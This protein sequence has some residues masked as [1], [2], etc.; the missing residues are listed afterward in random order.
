MLGEFKYLY[1]FQKDNM[2]ITQDYAKM[3]LLEFICIIHKLMF[4]E[5]FI[6]KPFHIE[7]CNLLTMCA[8]RTLP[9][10]KY[11]VIINM[12]FR[13]SKTQI[14]TYYMLWC[15]LHNEQ[16]LF[17]YS[18][19]SDKLSLKTSREV[20]HGLIDVFKMRASFSKDAAQLWQTKSGGGLLATTS[21][22]SVTG[23]G[24]GSIHNTPYSGELVI[25]DPIKAIDAFYP[26]KL[27]SV[28]ENLVNTF[29]SRRNQLD[30]TPIILIQQRLNVN[31]QSSYLMEKFPNSCIRYCVKGMD[32]KDES[33]FPERVGTTTLRELRQASPYTFFSQVQQE[34]K[35]YSGGFFNVEQ[36]EIISLR[37]FRERER[38]MH[39]YCRAWD[40]AGVK[41]ESKP[42][43]KHDYTRG[44]LMTVSTDKI[45]IMDMK[46]H[47]GT[48]EKNEL[49]MASTAKEDGWRTTIVISE[50]PGVGGEFM[51]NY[52]Q[53][54]PA[55]RGYTLN[56]M[57]PVLNKQLRA[58]P[59]ASFVN[60]GKVIIVSDEE[61][62]EKWNHVLL[63][64]MASFPYG[65]NDDAI[66][67]CAD[68]FH[69]IH[70][71]KKY[72]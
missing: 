58:A 69:M 41:K 71:V 1:K 4:K 24:C 40:L 72:I 42:S 18:T 63:E 39:F 49:L 36:I 17:I 28:N 70:T 21:L 25:D 53:S 60:L 20:K 3:E 37:E 15:F 50:D 35:A 29:W 61:D 65:Q 26:T 2:A 59:F 38:G 57:R 54:L 43:N 68:A 13:F 7:I 67:A 33:I 30:K 48:V 11:I 31:D 62:K 14:L 27:N 23:F 55:L 5:V 45:Y 19:Y 12:P 8:T 47:R 56:T 32:E 9:E 44:I 52:F 64:E 22:G 51:T 6:V 34:P 10:G 46:S 16:A 66:D